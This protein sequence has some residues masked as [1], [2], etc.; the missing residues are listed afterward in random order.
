M[1]ACVMVRAC[2]MARACDGARA[3]VCDGACV[4]VFYVVRH[5]FSCHVKCQ[6]NTLLVTSRPSIALIALISFIE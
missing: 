1:C 3:R 2:V 5:C 6:S 4:C